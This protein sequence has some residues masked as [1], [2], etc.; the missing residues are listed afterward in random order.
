MS[1][2][3]SL[4][5]LA[6]AM[7]CKRLSNLAWIQQAEQHNPK[8]LTLPGARELSPVYAETV[9]WLEKLAALSAAVGDDDGR[10]AALLDRSLTKA[11]EAT[12]A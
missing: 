2:R 1:E 9:R 11:T 5:Y 10:V 8:S 12:A 4:K 6:D 3:P 7:E